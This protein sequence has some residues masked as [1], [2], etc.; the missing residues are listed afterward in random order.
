MQLTN[1]TAVG[2]YFILIAVLI[3]TILIALIKDKRKPAM[4]C[5]FSYIKDSIIILDRNRNII[6]MNTTAINW[7]QKMDISGIGMSFDDLIEKLASSNKDALRV[8]ETGE[9]D[10]YLMDDRQI[11]IYN[12]TERPIVSHSGKARGSFAVFSDVTR[13]QLIINN[14]EQV[15]GVDSL[16]ALGNR[17]CYEQALCCMDITE[18]LPISI[19]LGDVNGLKFI[20]DN[21]GHKTGDYLL[22]TV[23]HVLEESCPEG[24][25]AYRIGGDEFVILMPRTS[26]IAA[27]ETMERIRESLLDVSRDSSFSVSIALGVTTKETEEQDIHECIAIADINMYKNKENDRRGR[28]MSDK[29]LFVVNPD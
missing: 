14:L 4:D 22:R 20:N 12:L 9:R 23:A 26:Q 6:E 25:Y 10:F 18:N 7:L 2:I 17:R 13:Y 16:T 27:E 15:S 11:T 3:F 19:I 8:S 24:A 29:G 5:I 28:I 21:M 1:L